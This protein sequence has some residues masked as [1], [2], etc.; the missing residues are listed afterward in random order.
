MPGVSNLRFNPKKIRKIKQKAP[1]TILDI[2]Q[3]EELTVPV[4]IIDTSKRKLGRFLRMLGKRSAEDLLVCSHYYGMGIMDAWAMEYKG[5]D[6]IVAIVDT[7]VDVTHIDL[8]QNINIDLSKNFVK[9]RPVTDVRPDV[10]ASYMEYDIDTDHGN[11]CAG[12]VAA[13]QGNRFCSSGVSPD[14][15]LAALKFIKLNNPETSTDIT[16]VLTYRP[17]DLVEALTYKIDQIHIYS[18]SYGPGENFSRSAAVVSEA[19]RKGITEGRNGRGSI[20]VIA[21]G[22]NGHFVD[23]NLD[24]FVN[25]IYTIAISSVGKN[26]TIPDF[27]Q[28]GACI[29]ASTFGE[30]LTKDGDKIVTTSHEDS[31]TDEFKRTSASAAIA[32]GIVALALQANSELTWRDVQHIIVNTSSLVGL[33]GYEHIIRNA[34]GFSYHKYF[35][36]GL[37]NASALVTMAKEWTNVPQVKVIN[38]SSHIKGRRRD[39]SVHELSVNLCNESSGCLSFTEHVVALVEYISYYDKLVELELCSPTNTRS[40]LLTART[41]DSGQSLKPGRVTRKWKFMSLQFWGE[42]P[43]GDWILKMRLHYGDRVLPERHYTLISLN[44]LVYGF[45][46]DSTCDSGGLQDIVDYAQEKVQEIAGSLKEDEPEE[47]AQTAVE[48]MTYIG[49]VIFL[50]I[51]VSVFL[52]CIIPVEIHG[53]LCQACRGLCHLCLVTFKQICAVLAALFVI[54]IGWIRNRGYFGIRNDI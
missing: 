31:C 51:T 41:S 53:H 3:Q 34:A 37:M 1:D 42:I 33:E 36:F 8:K 19:F 32:S 47:Q 25:S 43:A 22:D 5:K 6:M 10:L 28:P 13:V 30:G 16:K 2:Y 45:S 48:I 24:G 9:G 46:N 17:S 11:N 7:G 4:E 23:V 40:H 21:A 54:T 15:K 50:F 14:A 26:G 18:N 20:Y 35:G 12:L 44:L 52:L 38:G 27:V 39:E 49:I 29:L